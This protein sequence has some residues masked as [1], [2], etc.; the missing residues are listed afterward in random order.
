M[1]KTRKGSK[2]TK[3]GKVAKVSTKKLVGRGKRKTA[4]LGKVQCGGVGAAL[5]RMRE[6]R[7]AKSDINKAKKEQRADEERRAADY[8]LRTKKENEIFEEMKSRQKKE[9]KEISNLI[10]KIDVQLK[11]INDQLKKIDENNEQSENPIG[12]EAKRIHEKKKKAKSFFKKE[13][14]RL[15]EEQQKM[16]ERHE[17]E[18]D[19]F[20][21]IQISA[22]N[23]ERTS[24]NEDNAAYES[25]FKNSVIDIEVKKFKKR[26]DPQIKNIERSQSEIEKIFGHV[27]SKKSIEDDQRLP[28]IVVKK[29][30]DH[31]KSVTDEMQ[32]KFL[33]KIKPTSKETS[34]IN[35]S[36]VVDNPIPIL[37]NQT[38]NG[39]IQ[40]TQAIP[41]NEANVVSISNGQDYNEFSTQKPSEW[42]NTWNTSFFANASSIPSAKPV[43]GQNAKPVEGQNAKPAT[44]F[45]VYNDDGNGT[46]KI[47]EMSKKR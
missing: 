6:R 24:K 9:K 3:K 27:E 16:K 8:H 45:L 46:T 44:N 42:W 34:K 17:E 28:P 25:T 13:K 11:K 26:I 2:M 10:N 21:E 36:A 4:K 37:A 38:L 29:L 7:K 33:E 14:Q 47:T 1:S 41:T 19:A 30:Y 32:K 35:N 23:R 31:Y 22:I 5:N 20:E 43:E 39:T 15:E 18:Y 12:D 40:T